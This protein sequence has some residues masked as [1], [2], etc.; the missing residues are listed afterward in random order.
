MHPITITYL[1]QS[2][3]KDDFDVELYEKLEQRTKAERR[4]NPDQSIKR[5]APCSTSTLSDDPS[6]PACMRGAIHSLGGAGG[7]GDADWGLV[8]GLLYSPKRTTRV[9]PA[10]SAVCLTVVSLRRV[11]PP[12]RS[13]QSVKT[14]H[15]ELALFLACCR[16]P[17]LVTHISQQRRWL[18]LADPGCGACALV[19]SRS[20]Q[21]AGGPPALPTRP[22]AA[23]ARIRS[24]R[25]DRP[26]AQPA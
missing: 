16:Q 11:S 24:Q 4:K 14:G 20:F 26:R 6:V 1:E 15:S 25:G 2:R 9:W 3:F 21:G 19:V 7:V 10:A 13:V 8:V 17:A 18:R 5:A 22:W 23:P 12:T